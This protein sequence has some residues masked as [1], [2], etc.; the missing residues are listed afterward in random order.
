[1]NAKKISQERILELLRDPKFLLRSAESPWAFR[2]EVAAINSYLASVKPRLPEHLYSS[3]VAQT[4]VVGQRIRRVEDPPRFTGQAIYTTDVHLPGMLYTAILQSPHAHAMIESIDTSAA[5]ALPGVH[6]VLTYKTVLKTPVGGPPD[7]FV[8][9]QEIH[10][11]GEEV[12][13]VAAD[14]RHTA[15]DAVRLIKVTYRVLPSTTDLEAALA[16][17]APDLGGQGPLMDKGN[18]L[19]PAMSFPASKRGDFDAAYAAASVKHEGTYTTATVQH[20]TLEPRAAVAVWHGSD[21]LTAWVSTQYIMGVRAELADYFGLPRSHVR[22]ICNYIGGGFG[23][24]GGGARHSHIAAL[25]ARMTQRPV[26]VE[27]DRPV[28]FKAATHRFADIVKLRGATD[29]AGKLAAYRADAISDSGAYGSWGL[30]DVIVSLAWTYHVEN[31]HFEEVSTLTNR[32]PSGY[33]RCVGNPQGTFSQDIFMDELAEKAGKDPLAFRLLNV[34]TKID[35]DTKL[36]WASCG[37]V[38]CL[39]KGATAIGWQ[40]KWHKPGANITGRKAHG[41]G[42]SAH[43]CSHGGMAFP[44]TA[45]MKIDVD[46]SLDVIQSTT[47]IGGGQST[48]MLMFAAETVGVKPE[49]AHPS[50]G[51]SAFTADSQGTYGSLQ[52]MTGGSAILE[53]GLDLK[54]QI[55]QQATKPLPP[56]N[57]PLLPGKPEDLDAA[58]GFVFVKADPSKRV[59]I[60]KVVGSTGG[61]MMGRGAHAYPM[62]YGQATFAAGFAEVE[63]DLDTGDVTLLRYAGANDVGRAVNRLGVEQQIEG[64][65]AMSF[66]FALGEEMKF[67]PQQKFPI[68]WN[69]E[70]YAMPTVLETPKWADFQPVIVEPG[71]A[72]GPYGAKGVGEPPTSPPAPAIANAIY[73]AI[74]VRIHDAPLTRDKVLKAIAQMK[75]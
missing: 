51:D 38:E 60:K 41:I 9:N 2:D 53:A 25:L 56:K 1:M 37:I 55:L 24:K 22:V 13:V 42:M 58:D 6:A 69:W 7:M 8:L 5:E 75:Q 46:G 10:F 32:G 63:V 43:A 16:P 12:A 26:R 70:N 19:G 44:M 49:D 54:W 28:N 52:T 71:D 30:G 17:D 67:D 31:A 59:E 61:P 47:D 14:D 15:R 18:R 11:A 65:V 72:I 50:F 35:Q 66:G 4:R 29:G 57:D 33:Q 21:D 73:N 23:D 68:N 74:G 36:P 20:G 62:G 3:S 48:Q 64:G 45:M 34:E 27:Y 40:Q 39:Q